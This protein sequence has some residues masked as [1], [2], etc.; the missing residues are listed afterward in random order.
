L[1]VWSPSTIK[2][3]LT[4]ETYTG[5]W[6]YRK[7]RANKDL[8]TG[9]RSNVPR[10]REEWMHVAV[11]VIIPD[12]LF[13]FVQQRKEANKL[14]KGHQRKHEYA[15]GGMVQCGRCHHNMTGVTRTDQKKEYAYYKCNIRHS[16]KRYST[17]CNAVLYRTD[18]VEAAVWGWLK[19]LLLEPEVLRKAIEDYQ[20]QQQERIQPQISMLESTQAR[21]GLVEGQKMR[22]L[23]AYTKGIL[24]LDEL[25]SQKAMLDK[26]I[27]NL[28][29]TIALLRTETETQLL[30][31][32]H[33]ESIE[34]GPT[35]YL[36]NVECECGT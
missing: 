19:S 6:H 25:A 26:Q 28:T 36:P 7:T 30:T 1:P 31:S 20:R 22:L 9:R 17:G 29:R 21:L 18:I 5:R 4:N 8:Q 23:D 2:Y 24:T 33:I 32:E 14:Q 11:P 13:E 15:L 3:I 34:A 12:H 27:G 10:P 35:R 16:P